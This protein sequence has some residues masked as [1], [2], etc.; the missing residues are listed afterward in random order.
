MDTFTKVAE[1]LA[2]HLGID[3]STVTME[4]EIVKDLGADSLDVVQL[5]MDM[6]DNF[7]IVVSEDD[8]ASLKTVGDIVNLIAKG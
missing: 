1:L 2:T 3:A 7:G 5:L 4:S 6:E 8:A